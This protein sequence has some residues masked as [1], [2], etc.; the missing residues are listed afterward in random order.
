MLFV[1]PY[2]QHLGAW[3]DPL[4]EL[5]LCGGAFVIAGAVSAKEESIDNRSSLIRILEKLI[6]AGKIF[7]SIML[8][9]FGIAHF[10]YID[11]VATLVPAWIPGHIFW[12]YFAAVALIGSGAAMILNFK[13]RLVAILTSVMIFLWFLVLHIPRAIADPYDRQGN[14][15]TSV[16]E[17]LGFSGIALVIAYSARSYQRNK[18]TAKKKTEEKVV[19]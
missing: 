18:K 16:F 4:K 13:L 6:P 17:A 7:F 14:E 1:N 8:I 11:N 12:T 2:S 5:A 15:I 19:Y 9:A 10:L 3:T